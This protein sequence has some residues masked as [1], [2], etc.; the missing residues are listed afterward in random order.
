MPRR[1]WHSVIALVV[2]GLVAVV[3]S[4]TM[5]FFTA[6][7]RAQQLESNTKLTSALPKQ[8]VDK[9]TSS[10]SCRVCHPGEY[11]SWHRTFHRTMTQ[12]ASEASVVGRFDGT[13]INSDGLEYRVFERD[14]EY[15]AEMPDPEE[16]MYVLQAGK[17][18]PL[19]EIPRVERQVVM[20]TGSHHYQTYWVAGD[21]KFGNLLQTLPLVYLI[22]DQRWIPREAAFM[23]PQHGHRMVSQWNH[24]C[25]R[26]H[27]TGPNPGLDTETSKSGRFNTEVGDLG[28]ACEACHGP[29]EE[30]IAYYQ[31]PANRYASHFGLD[32]PKAI[33]NP[34]DLDH[35]RSS[36]VCGQ[37]HSVYTMRHDYAM[38]YGTEGVQFRP[39]EDLHQYHYC[40][41]HP[42]SDGFDQRDADL[43]R[44]TE[45][46]RQRWWDDGTILAGG[47]EFTAI[48]AAPCYQ[49]GELSCLSCHTM[50]HGDPNDQLKP[51]MDTAAACTQCHQAARFT[52]ELASHTHHAPDSVGSNCLNCHM[53]HTTYALFNAIRSHQISVPTA[54][55]SIRLQVPNAC[56]LC[57]LDQTLD[58]TQSH[59]NTWYDHPLEP[60]DEDQQQYAAGVLWMIKGN[61]AS[62]VVTVWHAGWQPAQEACGE[63]WLAPFVSTLL[64]DEY[65]VVRYV[66][67]R[68]LKTLPGFSD[69]A[70]D[71]L[72]P[73]NELQLTVK[74]AVQN[75]DHTTTKT[76]ERGSHLLLNV[77]GTLQTEK[78]EQLLHRRDNRPV[79]ISE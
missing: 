29:A 47:R 41:Q 37:C 4:A 48:S 33:V 54:T 52:T 50:H 65:G 68:S 45:F 42:L 38:R 64:A 26:C 53:P 12:P 27:S 25:I 39:G 79:I 61:A 28:I 31:N 8:R 13:T 71:F 22:D 72:A 36:Q 55:N 67:Y 75:W 23:R 40:L 57:H 77:E 19:S 66:A 46:F 2:V 44:N 56:N 34:V 69:F 78:L 35:K 7:D 14:G 1:P 5:Y 76:S 20:T 63:N 10:N 21:K 16:Y 58:W 32:K 11:E 73:E 62:R 15:W 49:R 9:Y 59:L 74:R 30:H 60:L 70:Y 3:N 17:P 18:T 51:G 43:E 6:S 24:Q